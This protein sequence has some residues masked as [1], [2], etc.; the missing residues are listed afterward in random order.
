L[1]K[2]NSPLWLSKI[3]ISSKDSTKAFGGGAAKTSR[4]F[5]FGNKLF[6]TPP[7][8]T[9]LK[10]FQFLVSFEMKREKDETGRQSR[11]VAT[12]I[13]FDSS[14]ASPLK[15]MMIIMMIIILKK[16]RV[17]AGGS[18]AYSSDSTTGNIVHWLR[19]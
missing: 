7:G 18:L 2:L 1:S 12:S 13:D 8:E 19:L 6:Q 16:K 4:Y 9:K 10:I 15:K 11:T 17:G 3:L 14:Q 5:I